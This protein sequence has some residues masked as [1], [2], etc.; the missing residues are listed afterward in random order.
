MGTETRYILDANVFLE[1]CKRY[2]AF[3]LCPGFW[4][5]IEY[6]ATKGVLA[7]ID[8]VRDE[9]Q[10]GNPLDEWKLKVDEP[11]FLSTD[12][13]DVVSAYGEII[14][15]A[16]QQVRLLDAAKASFAQDTDAW[17][18]A[19]ARARNLTMITHE[20]SAPQSKTSIKIPDVCKAFNITCR[21]TFEMLRELQVAYYWNWP[22][23]VR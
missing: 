4:H 19:C 2:Y 14:R 17:L 8:R 5:S 11:L 12:T 22:E 10:E 20:Q 1:A 13:A 16:Q 23:A 6:Y 3:D 7:S 21:N 15:W 9:L 18:I